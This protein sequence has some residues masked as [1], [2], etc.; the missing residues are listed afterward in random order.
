[1]ALQATNQGTNVP[2]SKVYQMTIQSN[3]TKALNAATSYGDAINALRV[4]LAG[5][6]RDAVRTTLLPMIAKH[7]SVEVVEG[8]LNKDSAKYETARKALQR[9][10]AAICEGQSD[11]KVESDETEVPAELLAAAAKLAKLSAQYEGSRKL[12]AKALAL[13]FAA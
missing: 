13:A 4:V 3:V 11:G 1:M 5:Q 2:A 8:K 6:E 7:Y 9:M 10:T 12:A